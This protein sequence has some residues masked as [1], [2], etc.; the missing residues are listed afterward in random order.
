MKVKGI[1]VGTP[2]PRPDWEQTNPLKADFIKNKPTIPRPDWNEEDP[3]SANYIKNKPDL[4]LMRGYDSGELPSDTKQCRFN[5]GDAQFVIITV[6]D[7]DD[8]NHNSYSAVFDCL[9]MQDGEAGNYFIPESLN[10]YLIMRKVNGEF[11]ATL[12]RYG[13]TTY[14]H[15]VCGYRY[16]GG[17]GTGEDGASAYEIAVANG[18]EGTEEEWL[19]SLKGDK[20]DK[21]DTG[22][23]GAQGE[24]G[25]SGADGY[26]PVKGTDYWTEA[27]KA[28]MVANVIAS[29]PV[30]KGGIAVYTEDDIIEVL[31]GEY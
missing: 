26:T 25:E 9:A 29:L 14:I 23:T 15:R 2:M 19:E 3:K 30:Y 8:S 17:G 5:E 4:E 22:A 20:G 7:S 27:D 10:N 1:P 31:G 21:G 13:S 18:F 24:Q 12:M 11:I 28:E 6:R 16:G